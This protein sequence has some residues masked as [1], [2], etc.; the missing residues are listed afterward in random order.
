MT[1]W[2]PLSL[3]LLVNLRLWCLVWDS[4]PTQQISPPWWVREIWLLATNSTTHHS[5]WEQDCQERRL[6]CSNTMVNPVGI[7]YEAWGD[8][9]GGGGS[10]EE[11]EGRF[12][13]I[14]FPNYYSRRLNCDRHRPILK[15]ACRDSSTAASKNHWQPDKKTKKVAGLESCE[16]GSWE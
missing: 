14:I 5:C 1:N 16:N 6:K 7:G 4:P 8:G 11:G 15:Q 3:G 2:K 10:R 13:V 12:R 9:G